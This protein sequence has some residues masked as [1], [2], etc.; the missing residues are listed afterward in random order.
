MP[1]SGLVVSLCDEAK[2]RSEALDVIRRESRITMGDL[3]AN[4]LAI[5]LDTESREEDKQVWD[6]LN[7]L[8]AVTFVEVAFVGFEQHEE[9]PPG[10]MDDA[11]T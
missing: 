6:W 10:R 1:I 5:V 11:P 3:E 8:P 7:A 4:R 9:S 2:R